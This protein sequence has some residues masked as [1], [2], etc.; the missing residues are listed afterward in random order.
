[1]ACLTILGGDLYLRW[2]ANREVHYFL[3]EVRQEKIKTDQRYP[4]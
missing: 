1:L 2:L 4:Q 3:Q